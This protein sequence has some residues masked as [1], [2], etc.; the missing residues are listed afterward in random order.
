M[1]RLVMSIISCSL[2]RARSGDW[3]TLTVANLSRLVLVSEMMTS[4]RDWPRSSYSLLVM[5]DK[6]WAVFPLS[7]R[8]WPKTRT[9]SARPISE[10]TAV[11][12]SL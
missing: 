3:L 6:V 4:P 10:S 8:L 5:S 7:E 12:S 1:G 11:S 9:R 2:S